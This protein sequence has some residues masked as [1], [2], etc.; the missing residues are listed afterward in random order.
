[1]CIFDAKIKGDDCAFDSFCI[2]LPVLF[3]SKTLLGHVVTHACHTHACHTYFV[4]ASHLDRESMVLNT[5]MPDVQ[6]Y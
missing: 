6:I 2:V 3:Y 4:H 1:M 5:P